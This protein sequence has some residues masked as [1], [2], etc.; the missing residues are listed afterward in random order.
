M[1]MI[2]LTAMLPFLT[3]DR[4]PVKFRRGSASPNRTCFNRKRKQ[5]IILSKDFMRFMSHYIPHPWLDSN[6][7][8]QRGTEMQTVSMRSL[9]R[10]YIVVIVWTYRIDGCNVWWKGKKG[11]KSS[12]VECMSG[13][14]LAC[15]VLSFFNENS[16]ACKL[17]SFKILIFIPL[18]IWS[19]SSTVSK[20]RPFLFCIKRREWYFL[21]CYSSSSKCF[22]RWPYRD[23]SIQIV[24]SS[25][26]AKCEL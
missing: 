5:Q 22:S 19:L 25:K 20:Y 18:L 24:N 15:D 11:V 8:G 26:I 9:F 6:E 21:K 1:M 4:A 16:L 2:G 7:P 23:G 17:K 13:F 12:R 3:R 10:R 14:S